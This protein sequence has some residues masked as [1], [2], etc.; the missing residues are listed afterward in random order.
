MLSLEFYVLFWFNIG[1]SDSEDKMSDWNIL[2]SNYGPCVD[3]FAPATSIKT[4]H[5]TCRNCSKRVSGTSYAVPLVSGL[6][7]ILLEHEPHLN[8]TQVMQRI[9]ELC[10]RDAL[11]FAEQQ[12]QDGT[13]NCLAYTPRKAEE[14]RQNTTS[15][16]DET[17]PG[18]NLTTNRNMMDKDM[19]GD[20]AHN[21]DR[22]QTSDSNDLS[23]SDDQRSNKDNDDKESDNK[24]SS[25]NEVDDVKNGTDNS[26]KLKASTEIPSLATTSTPVRNP[27]P[28]GPN[29]MV[30]LSIL[31]S[32]LQQVL[33]KNMNDG[34]IPTFVSNNKEPSTGQIVS[35]IAIF[36]KTPMAKDCKLLV[37][38]R[39]S[40][41][42]K[43]IKVAKNDGYVVTMLHSY[44]VQGRQRLR[45]LAVLEPNKTAVN[46]TSFLQYRVRPKAVEASMRKISANGYTISS[47]TA[48]FC[49]LV[50][51]AFTLFSEQFRPEK[52]V[53]LP[54]DAFVLQMDVE[55][56]QI[57]NMILHFRQKGYYI[58]DIDSYG[59]CGNGTWSMEVNY[60][61]LFHRMS[62][63]SSDYVLKFFLST[64]P[65]KMVE[66]LLETLGKRFG[67]KPIMAVNTGKY[68]I[69]QFKPL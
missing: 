53:N 55:G 30:N 35:F 28:L 57:I 45:F 16:N 46:F 23:D 58:R 27:Q 56:D 1:G 39:A 26:H 20:P 51:P 54:K 37:N 68:Y 5:Y 34:Y 19:Q 66:D 33:M 6:V 22:N 36:K 41:A 60:S 9:K 4:A 31:A 3:I 69:V 47:M 8:A 15:D 52:D 29:Y 13:P 21:G 10:T 49:G 11:Q 44:V 17:D 64:T 25:D 24:Q 43:L 63:A 42:R 61:L 40:G 12:T 59:G 38:R 2:G 7:A 65:R 50:R 14:G 18:K 62:G 67:V 48:A 32:D